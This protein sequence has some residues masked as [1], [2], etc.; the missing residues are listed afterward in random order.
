MNGVC[1]DVEISCG[2]DFFYGVDKVLRR[3]LDAEWLSIRFA[4]RVPNDVKPVRI[5]KLDGLVP[6]VGGEADGRA[7]AAAFHFDSADAGDRVA[8][9][10]LRIGRSHAADVEADFLVANT[11][12]FPAAGSLVGDDYVLRRELAL[13]IQLGVKLA[14]QVGEG[15]VGRVGGWE[16]KGGGNVANW[17][18]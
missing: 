9:T 5:S 18:M 6:F 7:A 4:E 15:S 17:A 8:V 10:G 13:A 11:G 12:T 2:Q 14:E 1:G 16:N 3:I